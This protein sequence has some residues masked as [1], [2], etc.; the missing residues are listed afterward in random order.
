MISARKK[1]AVML[2]LLF[3]LCGGLSAQEIE[4][5]RQSGRD[6]VITYHLDDV[7]TSV[8]LEVLYNQT[9][10]FETVPQAYLSG[11]LNDLQPGIHTMTIKAGQWGRIK[12]SDIRFKLV[13]RY[14]DKVKKKTM[15]LAHASPIPE[16]SYGL[17]IGSCKRVGWYL[18]IASSTTFNVESNLECD[19]NGYV[20]RG[21]EQVYPFY[22]GKTQVVR[23][24]G[25][26]GIIGRLSNWLY[27]Y[28]GGGYGVREL[29]WGTN[30][31][32]WIKNLGQSYSGPNAD[33]GIILNIGKLALQAGVSGIYSFSPVEGQKEYYLEP[34]FGIGISF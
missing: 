13:I 10:G 28:M 14:L 23:Y 16:L 25:M 29:Y 9:I 6:I 33:G 2:S 3:G 4:S 17:T 27:L 26:F 7:A 8:G 22:N 20:Q 34:K 5:V 31:G 19:L 1:V 12:G 11:Q 15:I 32:Q 21:F 30:D 24:S 18:N